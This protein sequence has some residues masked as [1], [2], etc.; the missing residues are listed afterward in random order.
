MT[1]T[2]PPP[3]GEPVD[4]LGYDPAEGLAL[5]SQS[6]KNV[7]A[8]QQL[9]FGPWWYVPVLAFVFPAMHTFIWSGGLLGTVLGLFGI[10][11]LVGVFVHDMQ[12]RR[13]RA[14]WV[15]PAKRNRV[16]NIVGI[17]TNFCLIFGWI[18]L[19]DLARDRPVDNLVIAVVGYIATLVVL[20]TSRHLLL[21]ERRKVLSS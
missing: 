9:D 18:Q 7:V 11:G 4:P 2:P 6:R 3:T 8:S 20:V 19:S 14:K 5:L 12:R 16:G 1:S 17:T 13:V 21:R 10:G 15:S